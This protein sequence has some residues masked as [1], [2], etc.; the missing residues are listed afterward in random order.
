M[1]KKLFRKIIIVLIAMA[2]G[3]IFYSTK[4]YANGFENNFAYVEGESYEVRCGDKYFETLEILSNNSWIIQP[5]SQDDVATIEFLTEEITELTEHL[6]EHIHDFHSKRGL[7]QK[8]GKRRSL[9]DYLKRT[10]VVRYREL[11][12]KLGLRK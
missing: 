10:D 12:D 9:L 8:V 1:E 11:I 6:K 3:I 2:I 7:L 4:S 5:S